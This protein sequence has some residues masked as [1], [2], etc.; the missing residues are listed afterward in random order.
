MS[1]ECDPPVD[2]HMSA[3]GGTWWDPAWMILDAG[4]DNFECLL[5]Q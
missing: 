1:P 4:Q 2:C 3:L 5:T